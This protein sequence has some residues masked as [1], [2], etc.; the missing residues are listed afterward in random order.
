MTACGGVAMKR[1]VMALVGLEALA[2][3]LLTLWL[4]NQPG[5]IS[6]ATY[7]CIRLGMTE[8]EV[9]SIVGI[10]PGDYLK[11]KPLAL[12]GEPARKGSLPY[13]IRNEPNRRVIIDPDLHV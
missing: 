5:A 13:Y 11:C 8:K 9:D 4:A 7:D 10:P 1:R 2:M 6:R 3:A 12:L